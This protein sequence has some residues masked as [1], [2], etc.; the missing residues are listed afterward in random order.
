MEQ[1]DLV[2]IVKEAKPD[3]IYSS[4]DLFKFKSYNI[5]ENVQNV[6]DRDGVI[7]FD[8]IYLK[9]YFEILSILDAEID[10]NLNEGYYDSSELQILKS[11]VKA[12]KHEIVSNLFDKEVQ[13]LD[14]LKKNKRK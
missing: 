13:R 3:K 1:I 14:E 6:I 8:K 2:K 12:L 5:I 10:K 7:F 9:K 4:F 11:K